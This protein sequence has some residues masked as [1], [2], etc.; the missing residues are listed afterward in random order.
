MPSSVR[1]SRIRIWIQA[2]R[3]F[4]FTASIAPIMVGTGL[5]AYHESFN[6]VLFVAMLVASVLVHA[7]SN[8]AN[9]YA[10]H[11]R[12]IDT[13][14]SLGPSGVIQRGYLTPEQVRAGMVVC[15]G[16][17]TLIGFG[18]VAASDWKIFVLAL[19]CLA[20]AYLYTGGPRPLGYIALGEITVFVSMGLG[21]VMGSYY[22]YSGQLTWESFF[23]AL[24]IALLV[25][26]ILHAN[27]IRDIES[28]RQAGK[29]TLANALGRR[30]ANWEYWL[31]VG[32]AYPSLLLLILADRG[33]WPAS[34]LPLF[35]LRAAIPLMG[36]YVSEQDQRQLSLGVRKTAG[37]HLQFGGL[38]AGGLLLAAAM[39]CL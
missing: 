16:V 32:L 1:P 19:V 9:D 5:A 18:I 29:V 12:G 10:D 23:V 2:V 22:V 14:E 13:Q 15:F 21:I 35:T 25:T 37:L 27:N 28:D 6:F 11:V 31:L 34:V 26:A 17:A 33:L 7:G 8:L 4:S 20:L 3:P 39:R 36:M 38:L 24:P 30:A